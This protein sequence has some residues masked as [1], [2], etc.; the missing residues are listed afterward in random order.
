M[1]NPSWI[2]RFFAQ[3]L[4]VCIGEIWL[5]FVVFVLA[6]IEPWLVLVLI[7]S[8]GTMLSIVNLIIYFATR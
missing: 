4:S 1:N 5:V 6:I 8:L 7:L 3:P 2:R